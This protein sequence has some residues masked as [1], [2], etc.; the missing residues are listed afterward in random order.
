MNPTRTPLDG[1]RW[2]LQHGP[3]NLVLT[4]RRTDAVAASRL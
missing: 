2:H 3:L 4:P 1:T